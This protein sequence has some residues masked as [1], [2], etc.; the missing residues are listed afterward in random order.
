LGLSSTP[1]FAKTFPIILRYD[2]QATSLESTKWTEVRLRDRE[3][4]HT[5]SYNDMQNE[6][7]NFFPQLTEGSLG[8]IAPRL[9]ISSGGFSMSRECWETSGEKSKSILKFATD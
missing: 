8:S 7:E 4:K 5:Y 9:K 1:F 2:G 3:R 6:R